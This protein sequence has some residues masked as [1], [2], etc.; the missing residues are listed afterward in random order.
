MEKIPSPEKRRE[1]TF[2]AFGENGHENE[3]IFTMPY[4]K[5]DEI[6]EN[7]AI[8]LSNLLEAKGWEVLNRGTRLEIK[9]TK[10]FGKRDDETIHSA[11][12]AVLGEGYDA[13]LVKN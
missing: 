13:V 11:I 7:I 10:E 6:P 3:Y 2:V 9:H 8:A 1:K 4:S 12:S 5:T